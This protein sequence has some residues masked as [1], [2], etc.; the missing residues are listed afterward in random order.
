MCEREHVSEACTLTSLCFVHAQMPF[1]GSGW[2]TR[3]GVLRLGMRSGLCL[4]AWRGKQ[5][6]LFDS[7]EMVWGWA[8]WGCRHTDGQKHRCEQPHTRAAGRALASRKPLVT[9]PML[10]QLS[11]AFPLQEQGLASLR[12]AVVPSS[13]CPQLGGDPVSAGLLG[14]G[15]FL[16]LEGVKSTDTVQLGEMIGL[17][18]HY[19]VGGVCLPGNHWCHGR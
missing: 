10:A 6:L 17:G 16:Y 3:L 11:R 7:L 8:S 1:H 5:G 19:L 14:A 9:S 13:R 18:H 2:G 12:R 15:L 4:A